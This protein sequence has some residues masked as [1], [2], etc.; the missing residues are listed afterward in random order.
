M[1]KFRVHGYAMCPVEVEIIIDADDELQAFRAAV[2]KFKTSDKKGD[3]VVINSADESH[4]EQWV[5]SL[6]EKIG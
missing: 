3:F 6:S 5:P 2:K 1:A 4:P